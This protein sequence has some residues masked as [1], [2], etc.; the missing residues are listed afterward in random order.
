M[1]MPRVKKRQPFV[2]VLGHK[3]SVYMESDK[4]FVS[5]NIAAC[6]WFLENRDKLK[7]AIAAQ[8]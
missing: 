3:S 5:D 2:D 7:T 8:K 4:D 6:V 1:R